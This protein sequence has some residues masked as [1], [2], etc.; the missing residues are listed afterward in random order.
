MT[1]NSFS[2][3]LYKKMCNYLA[4]PTPCIYKFRIVLENSYPLVWRE[5]A[6]NSETTLAELHAIIQI[7]FGWEDAQAHKFFHNDYEYV[8]QEQKKHEAMALSENVVKISNLNLKIGEKFRYLYSYSANWKHHFELLYAYPLNHDLQTPQCLA[9]KRAC[10]PEIC[11]GVLDYY[12]LIDILQNA[13]H[14]LYQQKKELVDNTFHPE[15]FNVKEVNKLLLEVNSGEAT[16]N[17]FSE[18]IHQALNS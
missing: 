13:D 15:L 2:D 8:P 10:P 7:T 4:P 18:C 12:N 16:K 6:V 14:P 1:N 17:K 9:G 5:I 3:K 11:T